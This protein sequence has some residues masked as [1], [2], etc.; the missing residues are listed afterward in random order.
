M[1]LPASQ[2]A[3]PA[4]AWRPNTVL[5]RGP[6]RAGNAEREFFS[7][8]P[9]ETVDRNKRLVAA[10]GR[11]LAVV[12][13]SLNLKLLDGLALSHVGSRSIEHFAAFSAAPS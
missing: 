12:A 7:L 3:L 5:E 13:T 9:G 6:A 11:P 10:E 4:R 8:D 2:K 1:P